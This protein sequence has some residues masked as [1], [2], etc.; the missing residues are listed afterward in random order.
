MRF[1][2]ILTLLLVV[3]VAGINLWRTGL[4]AWHWDRSPAA[5][6][7]IVWLPAL[8]A[9]F[10]VAF[11]WL[12]GALLTGLLWPRRGETALVLAV[13]AG[14]GLG[15]TSLLFHVASRL[16]AQPM[17]VAFP[18]ELLLG[19]GLLFLWLRKM[20]AVPP[21]P[22]AVPPAR[23]W[24]GSVVRM[25]FAVS[26]AIALYSLW[27]TWRAA[28]AELCGG[29][30]PGQLPLVPAGTARTLAYSDTTAHVAAGLGS[31]GFSLA[32]LALLVAGV[33]RLRNRL[34]ALTGGLVLLGTPFFSRFTMVEHADVPFGFFLLAATVLMS[35]AR[36]ENDR[37]LLFLAGLAAGLTAWIKPEGL[38]FCLALG[39][40]F[41]LAQLRP[42]L[43]RNLPP[44]FGGLALMLVPLFWLGSPLP[45]AGPLAQLG[46]GSRHALLFQA[47]WRDLPHFGEWY[48]L[49]FFVLALHLVGPGR[50]WL[51]RRTVVAAALL[52][53]LLTGC[54]A[55]W[56]L[57]PADL[58][59]HLA[60][61]LARL[62]MQVWPA[63]VFLWCLLAVRVVPA[64]GQTSPAES[65][66][67]S[68][69]SGRPA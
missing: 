40:V 7:A 12:I 50:G 10:A 16:S 17:A 37:G 57:G 31:A 41:G 47:W 23:S 9:L 64:A 44:L 55:A 26:G 38:V 42:R 43:W 60:G 39:L 58:A 54:A 45:S 2:R 52:L 34:I 24:L 21:P 6:Q 53:V 32:T 13:G 15:V 46:D 68:A 19:C 48:S 35:V 25:V 59:E 29:T 1:W 28:P 66:V 5:A 20:R 56:L 65:P 49:P 11:A 3:A 22:A 51:E 67:D 69:P 33:N 30:L 8:S 36:D 61:S 62:L 18:A 63:A 14:V 4:A 27:I